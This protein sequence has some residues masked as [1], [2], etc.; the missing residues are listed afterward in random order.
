MYDEYIKEG[1]MKK[2]KY[3]IKRTKDLDLIVRINDEI[4]PE[5]KLDV[6]HKTTAWIV[7]SEDKEIAGF[8]TCRNAGYGILYMDRGGIKYKHRGKGLHRKMISAR[9]A[10]AKKN[11]FKKIIT[12]VMKENW[13]SLFTLIRCDYLKYTPEY[14][15][16]GDNVVYLIKELE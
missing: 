10:Y 11:G 6:D 15:Y 14:K 8:C 4:F 9:E 7:Y 12:Y 1:F 3:K 16:A 2:E 13:T 5:D